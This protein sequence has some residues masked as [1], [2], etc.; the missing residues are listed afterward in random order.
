MLVIR[1][2]EYLSGFLKGMGFSVAMFGWFGSGFALVGLP[3]T[4]G[5]GGVDGDLDLGDT[6]ESLTVWSPGRSTKGGEM[7]LSLV[8]VW[9]LVESLRTKSTS[10]FP[11]DGATTAGG[12]EGDLKR[13]ERSP[14]GLESGLLEA[15]E[16]TQWQ[17]KRECAAS[18]Q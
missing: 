15:M 10:E 9:E 12:C 14:S 18:V 5:K 4:V 8:I 7:L 2:V 6:G 16:R 13:L 1:P 3:G 11:G 17:S